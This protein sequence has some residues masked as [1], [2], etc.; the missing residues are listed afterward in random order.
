[1]K[2]YNKTSAPGYPTRGFRGHVP[3][4]PEGDD[5]G[6]SGAATTTAATVAATTDA[7]TAAS[8][9]QAAATGVTGA[10][11]AAAA[12]DDPKALLAALKAERAALATKNAELDKFLDQTRTGLSRERAVERRQYVRGMTLALPLTDEQLDAQ[13]AGMGDVDVRTDAGKA[14]INKWREGNS[15]FFRGPA[16]API[17]NTDEVLADIVGGKENID[18]K[19]FGGKAAMSMITATKKSDFAS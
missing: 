4:A 15:T 9:A 10:T 5:A 8:T 12:D 14:A 16:P 18:R 11:T 17:L 2:V 7:T 1:M 13:L 6:A 3:M 19:I